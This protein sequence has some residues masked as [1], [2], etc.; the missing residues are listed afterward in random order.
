[1]KD[2]FS[3][4][5]ITVHSGLYLKDPDSSKLG[6]DIIRHSVELIHE[7]GFEKFSF[8]KLG[9][10]TGSPESTI[11]RYFEN[12]HKLLLYLTCWYWGW[13]EYRLVFSTVNIPEPKARLIKAIEI[14]TENITDTSGFTYINEVLLDRIVVAEAAKTYL[15]KEVDEE[16]REGYFAGYKRLVNRMSQMVLDLNPGFEFPHMLISSVIEGAHLQKFFSDHLPSVTDVKNDPQMITRFY[17]DMV[18]CMIQKTSV[19]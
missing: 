17:T 19:E 10:R 6:N 1:M 15:T 2:L 7:I 9:E 3:Q 18:F 14:V 12:K 11:Y 13:M 4:I 5:K 16:N 8:K